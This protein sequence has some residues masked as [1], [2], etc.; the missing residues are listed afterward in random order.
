MIGPSGMGSKEPPA[1]LIVED[2]PALVELYA[3]WLASD[4]DVRVVHS[5]HESLDELDIEIDF[6]LLNREMPAMTG[7]VAR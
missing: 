2:D 5:G 4:D 6:V 1:V 3:T 7:D